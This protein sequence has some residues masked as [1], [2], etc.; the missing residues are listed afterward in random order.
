MINGRTSHY[1]D[2]SLNEQQIEA[3]KGELEG[4]DPPVERLK[5]ITEDKPYEYNGYTAPANW[6][7]QQCGET[8]PVGLI[9]KQEGQ[10]AV[11]GV[12]LLKN[13]TWPGACTVGYRGGWANIYI[14][15]EHKANQETK[16]LKQLADLQI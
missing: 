3:L 7:S 8:I 4:Q 5:G 6:T 1:F 12:A 9:G 14:G 16:I 15:Y 10:N 11:Y 2:P 13:L